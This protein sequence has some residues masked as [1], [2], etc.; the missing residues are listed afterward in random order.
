MLLLLLL[1]VL[2]L[3]VLLLLVLLLLL[4]LLS[5]KNGIRIKLCIFFTTILI[6][7]FHKFIRVVFTKFVTPSAYCR[8]H[9][10]LLAVVV[11]VLRSTNGLL[12]LARTW[13]IWINFC[14][15]PCIAIVIVLLLLSLLFVANI[16]RCTIIFVIIS[17]QNGR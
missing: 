2:L 15:Y 3:L 13:I 17:F 10:Y 14:W 7:S 16:K 12:P 9:S 8:V 1:L 4:L 5:R 6:S 11:V